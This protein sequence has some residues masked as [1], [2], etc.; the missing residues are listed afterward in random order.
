MPENIE[1]GYPSGSWGRTMTT[2]KGHT[3]LHSGNNNA[4]I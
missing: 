3:M 4:D 2:P 1:R